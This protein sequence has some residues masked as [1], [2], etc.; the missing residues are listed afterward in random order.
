MHYLRISRNTPT[1]ELREAITHLRA[2]QARVTDEQVYEEL[3]ADL[4]E[5]IRLILART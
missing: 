4:D 5:L 3:S 1:S 2:K